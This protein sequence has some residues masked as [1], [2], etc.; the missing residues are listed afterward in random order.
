M[1]I[2]TY[3]RLIC[4]EGIAKRDRNGGVVPPFFIR[5][6][7]QEIERLKREGCY[8]GEKQRGKGKQEGAADEPQRE[9]KDEEGEEEQVGWMGRIPRPAGW[10]LTMQRRR[11]DILNF[12]LRS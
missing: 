3:S 8:E 4:A 6:K 12:G 1:K 2:N 10:M 5:W 9:E 7:D 11:G